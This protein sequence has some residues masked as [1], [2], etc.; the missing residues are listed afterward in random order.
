MMQSIHPKLLTRNNF[1][2]QYEQGK[3]ETRTSIFTSYIFFLNC[4][5]YFYNLKSAIL[6]II[7]K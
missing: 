6:K 2:Y 4:K 5:N 1:G 7:F 3:E